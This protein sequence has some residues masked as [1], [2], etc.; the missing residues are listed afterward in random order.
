MDAHYKKLNTELIAEVQSLRLRLSEMR[1]TE[2]ALQA[3][4]F[5]ER[6]EHQKTLRR[7]VNKFVQSLGIPIG[8]ELEADITRTTT[9]VEQSTAPARRTRSIIERRASVER[10]SSVERRTSLAPR[11]SSSSLT[12]SP[13]DRRRSISAQSME[14]EEEEQQ[15]QEPTEITTPLP[16]RVAE[17][18][19]DDSES[20]IPDNGTTSAV[21]ADESPR[22]NLFL[23]VEESAMDISS[24]SESIATVSDDTSI[25]LRGANV[26]TPSPSGR[27]LRDLSINVPTITVTRGMKSLQRSSA[28]LCDTTNEDNEEMSVQEIRHAPSRSPGYSR[29][30]LTLGENNPNLLMVTPRRSQ[31]NSISTAPGCTSTPCDLSSELKVRK[32]KQKDQKTQSEEEEEEKPL[33]TSYSCR[34]SRSCRPTTLVEPKLS[35]KLRNE[36]ATKKPT[37]KRNTRSKSSN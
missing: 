5:D 29:L 35:T 12:L 7:A 24:A 20:P 28:I 23:I 30:K 32:K 34:P 6:A 9:D 8:T 27:V 13:T 16:R 2:V 22:P 25:S 33:N 19:F 1:R 21:S 26:K 31:F 3:L 17:L 18:E 15:Q 36:S 10:R 4:L 11:I 37:T 14:L